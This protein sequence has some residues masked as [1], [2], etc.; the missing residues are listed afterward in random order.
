M[1]GILSPSSSQQV[2]RRWMETSIFLGSPGVALGATEWG[3]RDAITSFSGSFLPPQ[4]HFSLED[5][6]PCWGLHVQ[7]YLLGHLSQRREKERHD[8]KK[9]QIQ[10]VPSLGQTELGARGRTGSMKA[11][12]SGHCTGWQGYTVL[13]FLSLY[14]QG[15][16]GLRNTS[17]ELP[18]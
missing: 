13:E 12:K 1:P 6:H 16:E 11:Q 5:M 2:S 3:R 18:E 8:Q 9:C 14:T 4:P 17:V 10:P 15:G 7:L